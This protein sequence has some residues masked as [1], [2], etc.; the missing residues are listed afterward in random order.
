MSPDRVLFSQCGFPWGR[1]HFLGSCGPGAIT[2]RRLWSLVAKKILQGWVQHGTTK[3]N[4][5]ELEGWLQGLQGPTTSKTPERVNCVGPKV[6][7]SPQALNENMKLTYE[8]GWEQK[9]SYLSFSKGEPQ[10]TPKFETSLLLAS[11]VGMCWSKLRQHVL[12][13]LYNIYNNIQE[14]I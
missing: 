1:R 9:G 3:F 8:K 10:S 6:I 2:K 11:K 5:T 12:Y 4:S 14:M 13:I 7:Q